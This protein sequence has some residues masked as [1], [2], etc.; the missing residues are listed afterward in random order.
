[1][2]VF[3]GIDWASDPHDIAVVDG[4]GSLLAR[5]RLDDDASGLRVLPE[6]LAEAGDSPQA[7][8]PVAIETCRGLLVACLRAT[9]RPVYATSPMA[10]A[11]YRD[12]HAVARKKSDAG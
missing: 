6:V 10:A 11:R 3:C 4:D 9:G 12:R 8:I 7:P 1:M 5:C 2:K